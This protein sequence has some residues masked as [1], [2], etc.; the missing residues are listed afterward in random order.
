MYSIVDICGHQF[1]VAAGNRIRVNT[2]SAEPDQIIELDRVLLFSDNDGISVGRPLVSGASV[3]AKVLSHGRADKVMVFK[4]H[5]RKDYRKK[6]GHRQ[7]FTQLLITEVAMGDKKEAYQPKPA[8]VTATEKPTEVA[9]QAV[10]QKTV[11]KK[12]AKK[13]KKG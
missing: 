11:E 2:L 3:K 9:A 12:P 8:N 13:A 1:K 5:R 6:V 7:G 10:P 4:K